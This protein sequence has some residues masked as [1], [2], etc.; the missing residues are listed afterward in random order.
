MDETDELNDLIFAFNLD[1]LVFYIVGSQ[2]LPTFFHDLTVAPG[3][4]LDS[5]I[6]TVFFNFL[7]H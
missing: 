3:V 1:S 7:E 2:P 4:S 5:P 6:C